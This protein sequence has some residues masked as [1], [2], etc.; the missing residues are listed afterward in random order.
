MDKDVFERLYFLDIPVDHLTMDKAVDI[1][2]E[3]VQSRRKTMVFTPNVD[4]LVKAQFDEEFKKIYSQVDLSL[5]DGMPLVWVSAIFGRTLPQRINGTNLVWKLCELAQTRDA[6]LFLLGAKDGIASRAAYNLQ[7]RFPQ[8]KIAGY[9]SPPFE[10]IFDKDE[11]T[12]IID[13]VNSCKPD[14][15]LVAFGPLKQEKW[16]YEYHRFLDSYIFLGVGGAL[17]LI[18]GHIRRAPKWMQDMGLEWLFR[19]SREPKRL[20]KRYLFGN[21]IFIYLVLKKA[22]SSLAPRGR[23]SR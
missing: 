20:W 10:T 15:L 8:L 4:H 2:L 6:T 17:D 19:L 13:K 11:V 23:S 22:L 14:I 18:S 1:I 16:I 5:V 21:T 7:T 3:R 9:Y 12:R